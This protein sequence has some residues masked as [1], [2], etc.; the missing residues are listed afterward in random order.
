MLSRKEFNGLCTNCNNAV[1]CQFI[2]ITNTKN[3]IHF[4]EEYRLR[5][6]TTIYSTETVDSARSPNQAHDHSQGLCMSCTQKETCKYPSA[7]HG[8]WHCEDFE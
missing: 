4:C 7:L 6:S 8:V 2:D 5:D 3:P 1:Q